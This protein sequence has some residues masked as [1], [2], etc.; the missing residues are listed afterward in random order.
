[1]IRKKLLKA[2]DA[3]KEKADKHHRDVTFF[4]CQWVLLRLRP[5]C[6]V[7]ARENPH[8]SGKLAKHFYG[9]F[10]VMEVI[11]KVAYRLQLPPDAKIHLVFHCSILK[12]FHG[13]PGDPA[14][15]P[16]PSHFHD[17][18]PII[19]PATILD[20]R[21]SS[22]STWEVLVQWHGLSP[23]E[24]SREDWSTLCQDYHLE[25]KV[26]SQG[27]RGDIGG[28]ITEASNDIGS[29]IVEASNQH[30]EVQQANQ[31][32]KEQKPKRRVAKPAYLRDYV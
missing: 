4:P 22:A 6:Q 12:P 14:I 11:G 31:A 18:Q 17:A 15:S 9:P 7:S 28:D 26:L 10:Q 25:D 5:H 1:M 24:T 19:R 21:Q 27:P 30:D 20:S 16:L 29:H 13:D 2:Q 32:N 3:M 23:D 8:I